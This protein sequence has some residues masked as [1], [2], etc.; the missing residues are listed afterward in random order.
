VVDGCGGT[1]LVVALLWRRGCD[2]V[3]GGFVVVVVGCGL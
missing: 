3:F 1:C 2:F